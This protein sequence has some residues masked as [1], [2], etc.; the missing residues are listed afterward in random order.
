MIFL[1]MLVHILRLPKGKIPFNTYL[2][3]NVVKSLFINPV[4]E[5]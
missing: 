1:L 5:S 2:R 4:R 3:K